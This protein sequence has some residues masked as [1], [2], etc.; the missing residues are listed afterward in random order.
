MQIDSITA[1]ATERSASPSTRA[2]ITAT[3]ITKLAMSGFSCDKSE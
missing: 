1:N 3:K 2:D